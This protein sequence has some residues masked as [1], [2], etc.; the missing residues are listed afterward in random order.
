MNLILLAGFDD[1]DEDL[2]GGFGVDD[3]F[4]WLKKS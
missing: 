3:S 2:M 4:G 1:F